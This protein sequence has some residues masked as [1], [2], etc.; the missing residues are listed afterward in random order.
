M[1]PGSHKRCFFFNAL[2]NFSFQQ[3]NRNNV[4]IAGAAAAV[5][6]AA[7]VAK[8]R[9]HLTQIRD[10]PYQRVGTSIVN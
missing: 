2:L 8:Q 1:E 4:F 5:A 6:A 7:Q 9:R 3:I 10:H